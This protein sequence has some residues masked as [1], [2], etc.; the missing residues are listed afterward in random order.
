MMFVKFF[1]MGFYVGC[2]G[3]EIFDA[4]GRLPYHRGH[5]SF[6]ASVSTLIAAATRPTETAKTGTAGTK[7]TRK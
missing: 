4:Q 7:T 3:D 6:P 5:L 1:S 2:C